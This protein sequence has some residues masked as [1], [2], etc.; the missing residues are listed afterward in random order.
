M[1]TGIILAAAM[2]FAPFG[3]AGDEVSRFPAYVDSDL[4]ARLLLGPITPERIQCSTSTFKDGSLPVLVRLQ[5]NMVL[6]VN[7]DKLIR[8]YVGQLAD[9]SGTLKVRD[10]SVKLASATPIDSGSIPPGDPAR[11]LLDAK[12]YR[13]EHSAELFEKVRHELAMMPYI[14]VFDF[15][16]FT[17]N[18]ADVILTGWTVRATNRDAAERAVRDVKG[19]ESVVNNI[20]ILPLGS[21]DMQIRVATRAAL[22]RMLGRYFWG[23]GSDIKIVVKNGQII[24]LGVVATKTDSDIAFIQANSVP[25]SFKVFNMLRVQKSD[26]KK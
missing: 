20:E 6:S 24:L 14:S 26:E 4:C 17:Q 25:F 16:S 7:K 23:N 10:G 1:K 22:Q 9:I 12:S 13:N 15:I 19:V 11:R 3:F 2:L 8:P 5:N 18:G 21:S